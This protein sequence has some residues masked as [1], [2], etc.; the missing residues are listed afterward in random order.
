MP[1][2]YCSTCDQLVGGEAIATHSAIS[3]GRHC[4]VVDVLGIPD[5]RVLDESWQAIALEDRIATVMGEDSR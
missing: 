2:Y 1:V 5:S 4:V 3:P